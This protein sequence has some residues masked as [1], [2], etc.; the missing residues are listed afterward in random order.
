MSGT[1]P[2][3]D[4][5]AQDQTLHDQA[6]SIKNKWKGKFFSSESKAKKNAENSEKY[7]QDVFDF[8]HPPGSRDGSNP[9]SDLAVPRIDTSTAPRWPSTTDTPGIDI[10][11]KPELRRK[12]PR[13]PNLQVAFVPTE[14]EIIGEGGDDAELPVIEVS[15][16][17]KPLPFEESSSGHL[18]TQNSPR[19]EQLVISKSKPDLE[20]IEHFERAPL[21]RKQTGLNDQLLEKDSLSHA[22]DRYVET[23]AVSASAS[24][25]QKQ[26][27]HFSHGSTGDQ[28]GIKSVDQQTN[29]EQNILG[30]T[31]RAL[32]RFERTPHH[33][34]ANVASHTMSNLLTL[35]DLDLSLSFTNSLT[36]IPTPPPPPSSTAK[37]FSIPSTGIQSSK[38]DYFEPPSIKAPENPISESSQKSFN[39]KTEKRAL[40]IRSVAKN[41]GEDALSDFALRVNRFNDIFQIG[42]TVSSPLMEISFLQWIRTSAYWFLR[43]RGELEIAVRSEVRKSQVP[44]QEA[45]PEISLSLRQAYLDL[46][47]AWWI[48]E[49]ITPKHPELKRFG[50]AGMNPLMAILASCGER[51]VAEQIGVHLAIIANMRA[52]AMSMKRNKR[53]PP[54]SFEMQRLD[55]RIFV[56]LPKLPPDIQSMLSQHSQSLV[57]NGS[58]SMDRFFPMPVGDTK[59]HF[60]YSSFFVDLILIYKTDDCEEIHV[61]CALSILRE[62][63]AW[64]VKAV[65]ASQDGQVNMVLQTQA[66][67]GL[68]WNDVHWR[69]KL[70]RIMFELSES[71][72]AQIQFVDKDFKSLWG[73]HDY[74]KTVQKGLQCNESEEELFEL[75]LEN[76]QYFDEKGLKMF[77][78]DPA[79]NC[80]LR[81]F[82][83]KKTPQDSAG[84]RKIHNGHRVVIVTPPSLKTLTSVNVDFGM[85]RPILFTYLRG[86]K[87]APAL[88]L[89]LQKPS[90]DSSMVMTFHDIKDRGLFHSLIDGTSVQNDELRS[91][92]LPIESFSITKIPTDK[93]SS[94]PSQ[95]FMNALPWQQ[96]RVISTNDKISSRSPT[97][98]SENLRICIEGEMGSF[99]D[100]MN[101]GRHLVCYYLASPT[102]TWTGPG[103]LKMSLSIDKLTEIKFLRLQQSDMTSSFASNKLI[104]EEVETLCST[105]ECLATSNTIRCF[106]FPS[107]IGRCVLSISR[108]DLLTESE[109]CTSFKLWLPAS[110]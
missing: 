3:V 106:R 18:F 75:E 71:V 38:L 73:I 1:T 64:D 9:S 72:D 67:L 55:P 74:T 40:N 85:Q 104:K 27:D 98:T 94:S 84:G 66:G 15:K 7:N 13:K 21:Q 59:C 45:G 81:L 16:S 91:Q 52:L 80:L 77:Q 68:S 61:P 103:E 43:G 58:C 92:P 89:K 32:P 19:F 46:A 4:Q 39:S 88:R 82:E 79:T 48:V 34:T 35:P 63:T 25:S 97:H 69:V 110:P 20:N 51:V 109:V 37:E 101:L 49:N 76:F 26:G 11:K 10:S 36:P 22:Q 2:R 44:N 8:L 108:T 54:T 90:L 5:I 41:L 62:K 12:S 87:S 96:I 31:N 99:V 107:L 23:V 29:L 105:L 95:T 42:A 93:L 65:I 50:N 47:K 56:E 102:N 14:P 83:K 53:L 30:D 60:L 33:N 86:D 100:R 24:S 78:P 57:V 70:H 6:S 28:E 17:R